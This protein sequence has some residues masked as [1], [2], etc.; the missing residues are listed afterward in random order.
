MKVLIDTNI[1]LDFL[2]QREPFFGDADALFEVIKNQQIE[3]FVTATTLTNIFYIVRKQTKS[4]ERAREAVAMTLALEICDVN[5]NI[6]ETAF[7]SNLRDFE[8]AVQ[9]ACAYAKNLDAIITRNA[10]DFA[11]ASLPILSVQQLFEQINNS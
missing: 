2:L 5:R 1:A 4:I 11:G 3:G 8:D 6:L 7:A 10:D 9:L